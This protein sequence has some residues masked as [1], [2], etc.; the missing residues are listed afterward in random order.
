VSGWRLRPDDP[1]GLPRR[2]TPPA[3]GDPQGRQGDLLAGLRDP[4]S[5]QGGMPGPQTPRLPGG[6]TPWPPSAPTPGP[7]SGAPGSA[8]ALNSAISAASGVSVPRGVSRQTAV[9]PAQEQAGQD[10][11]PA[12]LTGQLRNLQPPDVARQAVNELHVLANELDKIPG[13]LESSGLAPSHQ[14]AWM[15]SALGY[16]GLAHRSWDAVAAEQLEEVGAERPYRQ[17][18]VEL[19]RQMIA[20]QRESQLATASGPLFPARRRPFLWRRRT[21]LVRD[22]LN[23]WRRAVSNPPE[24]ERMGHGLF[25]LRGVMGL[26][27]ASALEL[28]LLD[29][30]LGGVNVALG[31]LILGLILLLPAAMNAGQVG[32]ATALIVGALGVTLVWALSLLLTVAGQA[33]LALLLGASLYSPSHTIRNGRHG[34]RLLAGLLRGWTVLVLLGNVGALLFV[35]GPLGAQLYRAGFVAPQTPVDWLA[36]MGRPLTLLAAPATLIMTIA[37]ALITLPLLLLSA[38]RL[39]VEMF[40]HRAWAPA[41]R[42]YT[43]TPALTLIA[44]LTSLTLA[45]AL[46]L[47]GQLRL[48]HQTLLDVSG[49]ISTRLTWRFPLVAL[50]L[51]LPYLLLLE[52]PYRLGIRRWRRYWLAALTQRRME[53]EAHLR[54]LSAADPKTGAQDTTDENLRAMEYDLVLLQFYRAKLDETTRMPE[55]PFSARRTLL[56]LTALTL[57]ALIVDSIGPTI[58]H[59]VLGLT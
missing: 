12:T 54:R 31:A 8:S 55:A 32:I 48:D 7:A 23:A 5:A 34:S 44:F 15:Q 22:G 10:G 2:P 56:L 20:L 4:R 40:L 51:L 3:A 28:P 41:A 18:A 46:A 52:G 6:Q 24:P 53:L 19:A 50:A 29:F 33:P 9:I 58:A 27:S 14:R 38:Y 57:L 49:D 11:R 43:L 13:M 36:T 17:N 45:G 25:H 59:L 30:L 39:A 26:A 42:R 21:R 37:L 16:L 35:L 1:G 47:S